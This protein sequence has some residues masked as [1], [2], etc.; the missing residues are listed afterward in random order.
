MKIILII[1]VVCIIVVSREV[2]L[3]LCNPLKTIGYAIY[4]AVTY[5]AYREYNIAPTGALNAFVAHFGG[6]KTL[7]MTDIAVWFYNRYN[8][9]KYYDRKRREWVV[10]KIYTLSNVEIKCIPCEPL[11]T[12]GQVVNYAHKN[13]KID[14]EHGTR[15]VMNVCL[16][17]AS[18]QMNSR[19][20][21]S[22]IT[23]DYLAVLLATRHY[24][25]NM[26]YTTQKFKLTD[27]LLRS[28]T[29]QVVHCNKVWRFMIQKYYSADEVELASDTSM[30][31]PLFV[32]GF[33]ITNKHFKAYDTLATVDLLD[34][35]VNEKKMMSEAEIL[36]LR[37][38]TT[39]DNE[40]ISKPS[41]KLRKRRKG[42]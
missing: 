19:E 27:A 33:F 41:R 22:N 5:I 2:R 25:M 8:N 7:S 18:S 36:A 3:A 20:F 10:Q 9:K 21:R 39:A 29:Q 13:K 32:K 12:L 6:G 34:K 30:I 37:G 28:V 11:E 17:E 38:I 26:W 35:S 15:T 4:D 42:A 1:A 14:M 24:S 40:Q 16:D 23:A 31:Q